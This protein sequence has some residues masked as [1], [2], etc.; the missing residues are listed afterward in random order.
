MYFFS[1]L[2]V[3]VMKPIVRLTPKPTPITFIG[4]GQL[5]KIPVLL[6]M[7]KAKKV[8][9]MTDAFLNK[10]GMLTDMLKAIRGAGMEVILFDGV[11]PDPSFAIV[12]EAQQRCEDC[13]AVVAVGGGSVIDAA[14][15][16]AAAVAN[17]TTPQR[18]VGL[19]KVRRPTL[20]FIAVPTTA[21]TGSETTVAAIISDP[22][23][24]QKKQILSPKIVP[25]A[26][27]LDPDLTVQ[28]PQNLTAYT[29]MDALTHGLEAYLSGYGTKET[30]ALAKM[31][32][33]V[34]FENLPL[35][36]RDPA[37][38]EIR[39]ALLVA[40]F[41]A[42]MAFTQT[43]VGYV[44]AFAHTIGG[45]FGVSHGLANAIL[46]PH[47]MKLYLPTCTER[48][49]ELADFV[50]MEISGHTREEK[51]TGFVDGI[52]ALNSMCDIPK[53]FDSFPKKEIDDV[54][55]KSFKECHGTY[56]VPVYMS[57]SQAAELLE[58]V[59]AP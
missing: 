45:R 27:V 54:I 12:E 39:E 33:K 25:F 15:A 16:V 21:G 29:T 24:H 46:L 3:G 5:K 19:L 26:A 1:K 10:S 47:V 7:C 36:R 4:S 9:V 57:K 14:K 38:T 41:M 8:F 48:F 51:A 31:A 28:L 20:P 56:P 18:L 22:V 30:D 23:T 6:T 13:N 34:I 32:V 50:G 17:K 58:K 59:S 49:A 40:S 43:Y 44:H 37:N 35:A 55:K 42:G 53:R 11:L 52:F 2:K